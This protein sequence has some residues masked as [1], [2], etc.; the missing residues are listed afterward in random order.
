MT[1][2]SATLGRAKTVL[3][4]G[5]AGAEKAVVSAITA[6]LCRSASR[7]RLDFRGPAVLTPSLLQHL[8]E[9]VLPV[10]D[11]ILERIWPEKRRKSFE[12]S[13]VNFGAASSMDVGCS[14]SGFSADVPVLLALL[15]AALNVPLPQDVITT[16]HIASNVGDIRAVRS[17][18]AKLEAALGDPEI[19][20]FIH[21]AL[22]ADASQKVLSP[23]ERD[24]AQLALVHA[25]ARLK[26]TGV[27][28]IYELLQAT[29]EEEIL[30]QASLRGDFFKIAPYSGHQGSTL[31]RCI[32]FLTGENEDRFWRSLEAGLINGHATLA[33]ALLLARVRYQVRKKS[34]PRG[35]GR[36]LLQL[37]RSLPPA[38]R[39]LEKCFPL[40][41]LATCLQI[42][43][44]GVDQD[45]EDVQFLLDAVRGNALIAHEERPVPSASSSP[46]SKGNAIAAVE[47]V[48]REIDAE[49]LARKIGK[50][51][52]AARASYALDGVTLE[53]FDAY[54]DTLASFYLHLL[55]HIDAGP[56]YS[57]SKSMEA[58]ALDLVNQAFADKGGQKAAWAEAQH[59]IHGGLRFVLDVMTEHF[60]TSQQ[61]KHVSRV[62][63]AALEPQDWDERVRFMQ[64]F[65]DR[66]GPD[67]PQEIRSQPPEWFAQHHEIIVQ[68][69]VR[70]L[71]RVKQLLH[72][73]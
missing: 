68:T 23:V 72:R 13:V 48:L 4:F 14:L 24:R 17:L 19:R 46:P 69:Y 33:K 41:P 49:T 32:R 43:Q 65:L 51:I 29:I 9:N 30:V 67:L 38:I 50:P 8:R 71:D 34:Y 1:R 52:D 56:V 58:E 18:P 6:R 64:A 47:A 35:F 21:P 66:L 16:G 45:P 12:V 7:N 53:S 55:R 62:C 11:H 59:G 73:F 27:S 25:K 54:L 36:K 2:P 37:V 60:K 5:E 28:D 15:S 3:V 31:D 40:L 39:R 61:A 70:S 22:D 57:D 20:R 44:L 42:A 10:V 63:K 26:T